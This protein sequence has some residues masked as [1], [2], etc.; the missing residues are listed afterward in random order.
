MHRE[1]S[2]GASCAR[3]ARPQRSP[4]PARRPSLQSARSHRT[5][6]VDR[7][8]HVLSTSSTLWAGGACVVAEL[9]AVD[10]GGGRGRQGSDKLWRLSCAFRNQSIPSQ[11]GTSRRFCNPVIHCRF[12]HAPDCDVGHVHL[13]DVRAI[14]SG[15]VDAVRMS[16]VLGTPLFAFDAALHGSRISARG[17]CTT[18]G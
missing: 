9:R 5:P 15:G 4:S 11:G 1:T 6:E 7:V 18:R 14:T 17:A 10:F 13:A 16:V 3:S 12:C 8:A 2:G